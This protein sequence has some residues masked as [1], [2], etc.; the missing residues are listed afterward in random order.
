MQME[1]LIAEHAAHVT[2]VELDPMVA[3]VSQQYFTRYNHMD[4]LTNHEIVI[5]DA[6]HF[7]AN[8]D[9]QYDLVAM[10]VP[11]A[12]SIQTATL[13][14]ESFYQSV[15]S[16]LM[17]QG[18]LVVGLTSTFGPDDTVS[19]RITAT[20]FAVFDD[21]TVI[22][23]PSAGWSFA[24]ASNDMPFS[25]EEIESAL[26]ARYETGYVI[27]DRPAAEK[28]VGNAQPITLDSM[29]IVLEVSFERI[30]GRFD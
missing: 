20:L 19:R 17:P 16:H 30:K 1:A 27:F 23:A 12:F 10:D 14:S 2:T 18:V 22:T 8:T 28:V 29:D 4:T 24:Y 9:T 6:K 3:E 5:D 7:L 13:Y 25:L 15:E 11:A 26:Q 21:V